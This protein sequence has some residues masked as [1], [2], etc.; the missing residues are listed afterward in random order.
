MLYAYNIVFAER[1]NMSKE[2]SITVRIP[3]PLNAMRALTEV[4]LKDK[5]VYEGKGT[6]ETFCRDQIVADILMHLES[7][8]H[9]KKVDPE[10]VI[11]QYG[12]TKIWKDLNDP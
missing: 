8:A 2:E 10:I 9:D 4:V 6:V 11:G 12:L 5:T 1:E 7:I 3:I